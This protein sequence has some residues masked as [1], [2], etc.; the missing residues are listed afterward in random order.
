MEED[1]TDSFATALMK[2]AVR[3]FGF[4]FSPAEYIDFEKMY[5]AKDS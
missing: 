4:T 3:A 1:L 2:E 5:C